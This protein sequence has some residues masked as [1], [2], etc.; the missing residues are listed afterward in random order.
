VVV[1]LGVEVVDVVDETVVVVV[2][3]VVVVVVVVDGTEPAR[4]KFTGR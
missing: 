1:V 4:W 2:G 3:S